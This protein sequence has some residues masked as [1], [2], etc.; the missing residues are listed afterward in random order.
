M[1]GIESVRGSGALTAG[2][3]P[4][5]AGIVWR[6]RVPRALP[7]ADELWRL[8]RG[9]G[10]S[11]Y[12]IGGRGQH[13]G[14]C[15]NSSPSPPQEER[16]GERRPSSQACSV[17]HGRPPPQVSAR[18][19]A[20]DL[21]EQYLIPACPSFFSET[22]L[23]AASTKSLPAEV[24]GP[25]LRIA[26]R[27]KPAILAPTATHRRLTTPCARGTTEPISAA[28]APG[29]ALK[30][31]AM[32]TVTP[33]TVPAITHHRWRATSFAAAPTKSLPTIVTG[34]RRRIAMRSK[35]I[36]RAAISAHRRLA[37][38]RIRGT[39]K[40][41]SST[42]APG[43]ALKAPTRRT[44]SLEAAPAVTNHGWRAVCSAA[45][46]RKSPPT[47][48]A[49]PRRRIAL[50]S[51]PI[52][53]AGSSAHRRLATSPARRTTEPVSPAIVARTSLGAAFTIAAPRRRRLDGLVAEFGLPALHQALAYLL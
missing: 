19:G 48:V 22:T 40:S 15:P 3:R 53:H 16:A 51:K 6:G 32:K 35:P 24:T 14:K 27:A 44:V 12:A 9:Y 8:R 33:E 43:I 49:R 34:P 11:I 37:I 46:S 47:W 7:W 20:M 2:F 10:K 52:V 17:V 41:A 28:A 30:A 13:G 29:M 21:G 23:A 25:L 38:P 1:S 39:T 26:S 31:P 18:A 50:R 45:L 5:R 42:A 36:I 4:F